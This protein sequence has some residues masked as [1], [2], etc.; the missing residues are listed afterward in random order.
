MSKQATL[1]HRREARLAAHQAAAAR[2]RRTRRLW[3]LGA[4]AAAAA[5]LVVGGIAVSSS[6]GAKAK[7]PAPSTTTSSLF[8][9][10]PEHAGV[11]GNPKA[12][13]TLTEYLDLQCPICREASTTTIPAV[14]N[15][16][17][18]AGKV[19]LA[20]RPLQFIGQDSVRAA[21]VA[22]GAERQGRLWP[23][24][25]AFY[26]R[27]GQENSGYV[28]DS[29]LRSVAAASGVDANAA[30]SQA[31]SSFAAGRLNRAN[32]DARALGIQ[33]TPTLTV[34]RGNGPETVLNANA[35]DPAS[36]A[37]ALNKELAG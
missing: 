33:A 3:R 24:I 36:V 25:E 6:G 26:A 19:K 32:A 14:V 16:Y 29:F 35:L 23:F 5:V 15:Q 34:T 9:G 8:A 22:A 7:T 37:T 4:A 10:I 17:V 18:R 13:V 11:L 1:Q 21:Q 27:Q 2:E 28:T 31:G 30:L 12:P 20:A